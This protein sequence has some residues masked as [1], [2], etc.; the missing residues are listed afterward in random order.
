MTRGPA[1]LHFGHLNIDQV[2]HL[3]AWP[4]PGREV[5]VAREARAVG[6]SA[7]NTAIVVARFGQPVRLMARIAADADGRWLREQLAQVPNLDL[8][9]LQEDPHQAT[10]RVTVLV[11][12]SGERGLVTHR[13][14]SPILPRGW[15]PTAHLAYLYFTTYVATPPATA[16]GALR[17]LQWAAA[18]PARPLL[19][20]DLNDFFAE[21]PQDAVFRWLEV[22]ARAPNPTVLVANANAARV[23]AAR[24]SEPEDLVRALRNYARVAVLKMGAR[25]A[26]LAAGDGDPRHVP[27]VPVTVRDTTGAGDAFNAGL[28]VGASAGWDWLT[29]AHLAGVLGALATTVPG[30]GL[31]LPGP[32]AVADYLRAHPTLLPRPVRA[33]LL[34]RVGQDALSPRDDRAG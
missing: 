5:L 18:H 33:R 16:T 6:G 20:L 22:L 30:A 9:D 29:S 25:G 4:A 34:E 13:G 23:L 10:G 17:L 11:G 8:R 7:A 15:T 28:L 14:P 32:Q 31:A 21:R 12:P 26:W 1:G 24:A 2:L 19:M 27:P 3:D